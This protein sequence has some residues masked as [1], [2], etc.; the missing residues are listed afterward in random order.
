MVL[1]AFNTCFTFVMMFGYVSL[2][3]QIFPTWTKCYD[4]VDRLLFVVSFLAAT[5]MVILWWLAMY[6]YV[7]TFE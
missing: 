5:S 4:I 6:H 3:Q 7:C 1:L 2:L